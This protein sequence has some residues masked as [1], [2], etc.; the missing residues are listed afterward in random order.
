[1]TRSILIAT[2]HTTQNHC[3]SISLNF[4][5]Q[6]VLLKFLHSTLVSIATMAPALVCTK[7]GPILYFFPNVFATYCYEYKTL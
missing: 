4:E 2:F 3:Q 1:M 7:S 5:R 6:F